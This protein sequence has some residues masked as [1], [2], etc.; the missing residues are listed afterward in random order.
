MKNALLVLSAIFLCGSIFS[1]DL[2]KNPPYVI[3][4][5]NDM[6]NSQNLEIH[7][8]FSKD[9]KVKL[10]N[11]CQQLGLLVFE[12]KD[13]VRISSF[14]IEAYLK[15]K[16]AGTSYRN[17]SIVFPE[18]MTKDKVNQD[19]RKEVARIQNSNK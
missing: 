5:I 15:V 6:T 7:D 3:L 1:T 10:I 18:G 17:K 19:C 13:G 9:T 16:L 14:E 2:P 8:L 4:A 12:S 11:S